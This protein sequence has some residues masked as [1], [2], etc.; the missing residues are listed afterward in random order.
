[1]PAKQLWGGLYSEDIDGE[2]I[3]VYLEQQLECKSF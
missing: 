1:M 3:N 2:K